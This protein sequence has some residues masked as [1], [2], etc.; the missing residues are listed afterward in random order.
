MI[1]ETLA[2]LRENRRSESSTLILETLNLQS[3]W[4]ALL[5]TSHEHRTKAQQRTNKQEELRTTHQTNEKA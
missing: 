2:F 5:L 1:K 3:T 4:T